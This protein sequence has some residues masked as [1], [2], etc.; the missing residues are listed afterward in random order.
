MANIT[1]STDVD[2]LLKSANNAAALEISRLLLVHL[3]F[4]RTQI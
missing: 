1:V 4:T 2:A 3:D